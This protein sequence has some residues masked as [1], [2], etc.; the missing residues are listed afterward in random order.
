MPRVGSSKKGS[1]PTA[2]A[3]VSI[4][5]FPRPSNSGAPREIALG[6][7]KAVMAGGPK[8]GVPSPL[9]SGAS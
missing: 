6:R 8:N 2:G 7:P 3:V 5:T 4:G 9:N 1:P